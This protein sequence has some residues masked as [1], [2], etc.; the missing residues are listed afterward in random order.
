MKCYKHNQRRVCFQNIFEAWSIYCFHKEVNTQDAL[1]KVVL[2]NLCF[3][4]SNNIFSIKLENMLESASQLL[5]L[6][7]PDITK[8]LIWQSKFR[9][10]Y[11]RNSEK[12]PRYNKFSFYKTLFKS[13][14]HCTSKNTN[15][16]KTQQTRKYHSLKVVNSETV[17]QNKRTFLYSK[18]THEIRLD[19]RAN[20]LIS[21]VPLKNLALVTRPH[22]KSANTPPGKKYMRITNS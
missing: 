5:I 12:N 16:K 2:H 11:W 6:W 8:T 21:R 10:L 22:T 18:L 14:F 9:F 17:L 1:K 4:P 19:I 20:F 13:L 3:N 15:L 7:N